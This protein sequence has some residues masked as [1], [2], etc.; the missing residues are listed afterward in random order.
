VS[1]TATDRNPPADSP[2]ALTAEDLAIPGES[3]E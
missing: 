2:F 3:G 1:I